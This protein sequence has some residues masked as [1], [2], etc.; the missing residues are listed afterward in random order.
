MKSRIAA[1]FAALALASFGTAGAEN[2][3]PATPVPAKVVETKAALR[4]LWV[5][6]VF[7]VRNV[8]QARLANDASRAKAYEQ[9]VV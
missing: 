8:V 2:A 6:H 5:G 9:E 3:K 1:L 4:D 7:W